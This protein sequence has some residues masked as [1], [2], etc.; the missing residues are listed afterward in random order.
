GPLLLP[1]LPGQ[2]PHAAGAHGRAL[3]DAAEGVRGRAARLTRLISA[4]RFRALARASGR[5]VP[6][7][8]PRAPGSPAELV[9]SRAGSPAARAHET[10]VPGALLPSGRL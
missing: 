6:L 2:L 10:T 1:D 3:R 5:A 7:P 9:S 4:P 8:S